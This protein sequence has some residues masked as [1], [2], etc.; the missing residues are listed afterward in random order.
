MSAALILEQ[1]R[2][3]GI[4]LSARSGK[5]H[6]EAPAGRL[7]PELRQALAAHKLEVIAALHGLTLDDL[8]GISG[9]DWPECERDPA[10]LD[11]LARSVQTRRMRERGIVP[12]HYTVLTFCRGCNAVVSIYPGVAEMVESCPWCFNRVAGRPVPKP[13]D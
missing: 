8:R 10:V 2:T 12:P 4:V 3:L 7:T 6:Y 11:A 9:P 5:L 13:H 1:A